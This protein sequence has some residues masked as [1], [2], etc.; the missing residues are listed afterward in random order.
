MEEPLEH[1]GHPKSAQPGN[2]GDHAYYQ[3]LQEIYQAIMEH[4]QTIMFHHDL[5]MEHHRT[6]QV[7]FQGVLDAQHRGQGQQE[8]LRNYH[9]ELQK[10]HHMVEDHYQLLQEMQK[11]PQ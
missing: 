4:H 1:I 11:P 7:L 3:R 9:E 5:M 10:H 8:A 2:T 6:V